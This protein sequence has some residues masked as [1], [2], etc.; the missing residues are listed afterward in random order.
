[1]DIFGG[2]WVGVDTILLDT[3][4]FCF[5][6]CHCQQLL[7]WSIWLFFF[8]GRRWL[9]GWL[10]PDHGSGSL[11]LKPVA[12]QI[13]RKLLD[14]RLVSG[15]S[16]PVL[17]CIFQSCSR[18]LNLECVSLA[19]NLGYVSLAF[20]TQQFCKPFYFICFLWV[21]SILCHWALMNVGFPVCVHHLSFISL[22]SKL[23]LFLR[24][25]HHQDNTK[26]D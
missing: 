18:K 11:I 2:G 19:L 10:F 25:K 6:S 9:L 14:Y 1:M 22:F 16:S 12:S 23:H 5:F 8:S 17:Q 21:D 3:L 24:R 7:L 13:S 20:L 15:S 26:L 4:G